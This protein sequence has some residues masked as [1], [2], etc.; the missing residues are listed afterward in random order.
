MDNQYSL[1]NQFVIAM[2]GLADPN[3]FHAVAYICEHNENGAMGIVINQPMPV[4]LGEVLRQLDIDS[5]QDA[6][7]FKSVYMGGPVQQ[8]RG[9]VIHS[10]E[11]GWQATKAIDERLSVTL[12]KDV[13][14]A[15]AHGSGPHESLVSLGYCGWGPGQLE[16]EIAN[17][18]WLTAQADPEIIFSVDP[19]ERWSAA[20]ALLGVDI[21]AIIS[22]HAGHA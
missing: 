15:I 8:D 4:T 20:A 12:S 14:N 9:F 5:K 18:Y 1:L 7:N 19:Q 3:F 11:K 22:E 10:S 21:N 16:T 2:P 13:L 17:N 6:V